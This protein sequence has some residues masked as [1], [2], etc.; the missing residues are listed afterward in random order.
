MTSA[1]LGKPI[2]RVSLNW[3]L[4]AQ[5]LVIVPFSLHIPVSLLVLWLAC[6]FWRI[7]IFRMRVR[8]PGTWVKSGL[9]VGTAGGIFLARGSLVGLD[10]GAALLIAALMGVAVVQK[11]V[12]TE[13]LDGSFFAHLIDTGALGGP[14][15]GLCGS[16]EHSA[17][18]NVENTSSASLVPP[19]VATK[20]R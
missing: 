10:A 11:I 18:L 3:L 15:S 1:N 2:P 4:I 9:L 19:W 20:K 14:S 8:M 7:Q 17:S 16:C 13:F 5:A 6:S 12:A